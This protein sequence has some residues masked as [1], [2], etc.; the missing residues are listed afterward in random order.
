MSI[1]KETL[2]KV[3]WWAW[4]LFPIAL[5]ILIVLFFRRGGGLGG[6]LPSPSLGDAPPSSAAPV[7][8]PKQGEEIKEEIHEEAE[9]ER[10]EITKE[11][12]EVKKQ[13]DTWLKDLE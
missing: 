2:K 7:V 11:Q 1:F 13:V 12:D 4:V 6:F 9:A 3:P 10:A 5:V 8:T